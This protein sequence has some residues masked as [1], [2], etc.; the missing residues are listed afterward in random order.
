[1]KQSQA[2]GSN[3][4]SCRVV[5]TELTRVTINM[6]HYGG[7]P[8]TMSKKAKGRI[9][10][11]MG[12]SPT[13]FLPLVKGEEGVCFPVHGKTN[14]RRATPCHYPFAIASFPQECELLILASFR[15]KKWL[16]AMKRAWQ[17]SPKDGHKITPAL[18]PHR[19]WHLS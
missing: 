5:E 17:M 15:N 18:P 4:V 1:M 16:E 7:L 2:R 3:E 14:L 8:K 9:P 12:P 19:S 13:D 11:F 6:R 10:R